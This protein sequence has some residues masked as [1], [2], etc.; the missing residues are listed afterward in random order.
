MVGRTG[1]W[2]IIYWV[3]RSWEDLVSGEPFDRRDFEAAD[4]GSRIVGDTSVAGLIARAEA[5][6]LE[7]ALRGEEAQF[8]K[9]EFLEGDLE[10][11][12]VETE[13]R[14]GK[15]PAESELRRAAEAALDHELEI[16]RFLL[17]WEVAQ[18]EPPEAVNLAIANAIPDPLGPP[19]EPSALLFLPTT[20][21]WEVYAYVEGLWNHPSDRLIKAAKGWHE[22][23]GAE[24]VLVSPFTQLRVDR[25]PSDISTAWE[26]AREHFELARDTLVLPGTRV[27]DYARAL[28]KAR[29]WELKSKP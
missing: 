11:A 20:R 3:S 4:R 1:R 14:W 16:E 19:L 26:V 27:R 15:R 18:G 29:Y 23:F 25:P 7:E 12:L 10:T 9:R 6:D 13:E 2:P 17:K 5:L 21:P 24:C 22:R 28:M 8:W